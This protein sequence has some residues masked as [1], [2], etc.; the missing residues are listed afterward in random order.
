MAATIR[1]SVCSVRLP[2]SRENSPSCNTRRILLCTGSGISPISSRN[3]RPA[4]ALLETADALGDRPGKR[5]FFVAEKLAFQQRLRDGGAVDRHEELVAA[6]AVMMDRTRD[7][8]LARAALAGDHHR[9]LAVR[10]AAY[11]LEDLLHRL[12]LPDD[13][14]LVLVDGELRLE[15]RGRAH[16]GSAP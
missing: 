7:Q 12:G 2:P 13:A 15:R 6:P 3:K 8:F 5:P 1:T 11:H 9:G 4:V 14:V 16:L 10:D